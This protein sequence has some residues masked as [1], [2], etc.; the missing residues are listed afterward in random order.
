MITEDMLAIAAGEV[1]EAMVSS[2]PVQSHRFSPGFEWKLRTLV[3]RAEHPVWYQVQRAAAILVA[4]VTAFGALYM[5]SPTVRAAVDGWVRSTFGGY[6]QYH[7]EETTPPDTQYEYSLP[8]EFDGYVLTA[9]VGDDESKTFIYHNEDGQ[10]LTFQYISSATGSSLFLMGME[11]HQYIYG[12]VG[13]L[14]ADIYIA[15]TNDES[16]AIIWQ[17]PSGNVLL[18]ISAIADQDAL[19]AFAE[20][21]EK[22]KKI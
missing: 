1:S 5:T 13:S 18:R 14:P 4:A 11:K 12:Y 8:E 7:T 21:V 15:P 22:N 3:R 2:I 16:S 19:T 20:K 10:M 9:E 17:D 6:F